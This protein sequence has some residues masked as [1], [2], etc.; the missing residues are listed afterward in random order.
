MVGRAGGSNRLHP[1]IISSKN[2]IWGLDR[3]VY[4][5]KVI[6]ELNRGEP[7]VI[8]FGS[9]CRT[10]HEIS[11]FKLH[12]DLIEDVIES[13]DQI[14]FRAEVTVDSIGI[15]PQAGSP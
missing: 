7:A 15:D 6:L 1:I 9:E 10:W 14:N 13:N 11:H 4:I 12:V 3:K 2:R 8:R 5:L